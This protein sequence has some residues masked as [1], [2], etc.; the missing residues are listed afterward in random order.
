MLIIVSSFR[1]FIFDVNP[2]DSGGCFMYNRVCSSSVYDI[3]S[4]SL[5]MTYP[6]LF[7]QSF[8]CLAASNAFFVL[9]N[10]AASFC[11]LSSHLIFYLPLGLLP[12]KF[13]SRICFLDSVVEPPYYIPSINWYLF[14]SIIH[15]LSRSVVHGTEQNNGATE[16][17]SVSQIITAWRFYF[18]ILLFPVFRSGK[19]RWSSYWTSELKR[20]GIEILSYCL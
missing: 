20:K 16:R 6:V 19:G 7:L 10:L 8:L 9:S 18:S 17:S 3:S 2:L 4:R 13:S 5:A 15:L 12:P 14:D 1:N 11:I